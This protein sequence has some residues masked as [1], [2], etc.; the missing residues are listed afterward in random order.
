MLFSD[1]RPILLNGIPELAS[2]SD[3][4]DRSIII[5]LPEISASA[6]KYESELWKSF[7]EAA[8][9][10]LAGLLDGISCAVGRIGEV[11]LSERP[12]MADFAKWVSSAE[13]AYGWPEGAFLDSYA[14]NRRSTVQATIEGNPVALAVTLLAREGGSWQGTMT[15]LSKTLRARYPHI[16]EDTFGFPR[17]ANKLSSAIR[18]LKPP[19]REIGVE[20]GFDRQGQG[21]ERIVKINKV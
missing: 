19:L 20:V 8:P 5:H 16:T 4:A 7:N 13:L 11:K 17:H 12:R 6:R 10:I 18:R 14:A 21:S 9:R 3:L 2:R 1:K 15:E